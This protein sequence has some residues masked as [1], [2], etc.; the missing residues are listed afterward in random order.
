MDSRIY[1]F[2]ICIG[3]SARS[4]LALLPLIEEAADVFGQSCSGGLMGKFDGHVLLPAVVSQ[5]GIVSGFL[6]TLS[7][8]SIPK[9]YC[10]VVNYQP[11]VDI[12]ELRADLKYFDGEAARELCSTSSFSDMS[13][14]LEGMRVPNMGGS[15]ILALCTGYT[16][17]RGRVLVGI[18]INILDHKSRRY[19]AQQAYYVYE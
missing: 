8:M 18:T 1:G 15:G 11:S 16:L 4:A 12:P 3:L 10:V 13:T 2:S 17:D 7:Q 6:I 14:E 9:T 19:T 5:D